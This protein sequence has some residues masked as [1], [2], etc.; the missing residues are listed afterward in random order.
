MT[1][2]AVILAGGLGTRMQRPQPEVRLDAPTEQVA[3]E[4]WKGLVYCD[5]RPFLDY[6][7]QELVEAGFRRVCLVVPPGDSPLRAY[8]EALRKHTSE[9][10]IDFAVQEEPRGTADAVAA[11]QE[12]V[13]EDSFAVLNGDNLY[14]AP[15]LRLLR[16]APAGACYACAYEREP[17]IAK[18]N[19][20]PARIARYA[21]MQ[22][23]SEGRLLRIVEKPENPEQYLV[24]GTVLVSMNLFRFT[25]DIFAA[26]HR[27]E[28]HPVRKELELTSAVQDLLDREVVPFWVIRCREGVLDLTERG[29]ILTV[30]RALAGRRITFARRIGWGK[31]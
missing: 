28:P 12:F 26:C 21:V 3:D 17:L 7:L 5:G 9:L 25:P 1:D 15:A 6:S 8:Y 11:A 2:K 18:S 30:R 24:E 19:I 20:E 10:E 14:T 29:D 22:V 4:G 23:N 31:G 27:I 13:G 16:E